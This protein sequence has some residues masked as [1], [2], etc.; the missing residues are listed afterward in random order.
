MA[1][2]LDLFSQVP[3]ANRRQILLGAASL[4]GTSVL[5]PT[6]VSAQ[7]GGCSLVA[8]LITQAQSDADDPLQWQLSLD[9]LAVAR[10]KDAVATLKADID[11][12]SGVVDN[13]RRVQMLDYADAVGSSLL[14][15]S[16]FFVSLG[17]LLVA[18]VAF[19][20]T[21]LVVRAVG[22]P[23]APGQTEVLMNVGGSRVPSVMEAFGEGAGVVSR[24]AAKYGRIAGNV[25]G[26]VFVLYSGYQFARSTAQFQA[27]TA[28][29]DQL[30]GTLAVLESDLAALEDQSRLAA[31]RRA[32][33]QAVVDDLSGIEAGFCASSQP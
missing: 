21:M 18:S 30:R 7:Q 17:P 28:E 19:A 8:R 11:S 23:Q 3:L 1:N 29:I 10:A 2:D 27:S 31:M 24:N 32:C 12:L 33:A 6:P 4:A 16:G 9:P 20:G 25:S 13:N 14:L 5:A 26:A 22:S 15:I